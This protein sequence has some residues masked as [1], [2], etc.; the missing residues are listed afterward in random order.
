M[1]I[2]PA[3]MEFWMVDGDVMIPY[4][5]LDVHIKAHSIW[6]R[7]GSLVTEKDPLV[8]IYPGTL[9]F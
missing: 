1:D 4:T 2:Q 5:N 9:T 3:E 7:A 8:N 6:I